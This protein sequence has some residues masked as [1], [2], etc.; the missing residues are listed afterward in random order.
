[1]VR[2]VGGGSLLINNVFHSV[3]IISLLIFKVCLFLGRHRLYDY[4]LYKNIIKMKIEHI[5]YADNEVRIPI[6]ENY[7]DCMTLIKSDE[8]RLCGKIRSSASIIIK[9]LKPYKNSI[10]FWLRLSS[11]K[12]WL[13]PFCYFMYKRASARYQIQIPPS[14]KI[15]YGFYLGHKICMVINSGTIIGNNVNLS[16]FLNIGTNHDTPAIIADNVYVGPQVSI[17]ENV[18]INKKSTIG[19]GAVVTK[20]VPENATV[21]GVPAKILN[22]NNPG[23]YINNPYPHMLYEE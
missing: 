8:F 7:K 19:A 11:Y 14:C 5:K 13:Y 22:Y 20:D 1:M 6:A 21:A 12:G 9:N 15:G 18:V 10:L 3:L 17:V 4:L 23:Y 2:K 16:Q